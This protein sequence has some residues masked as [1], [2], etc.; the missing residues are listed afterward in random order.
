MKITFGTDGWR[1]RMDEYFNKENVKLIAKAIAKYVYSTGFKRGIFIGYDGRYNSNVFARLCAE[2]LSSFDIPSFLPPR[3]VPT[4]VAAFSVLKY[5]LDGAIMITASHNPPIYNGIK[6]IPHYGGP[7]TVEITNLIENLISK[8]GENGKIINELIFILNP[9]DDYI[10]HLLNLLSSSKLNIKVI[11]D[12]MHG[13]MAGIA[14]EVLSRIGMK[15]YVIRGNID[16]EFGGCTPDPIPKNLEELR[17]S[18]LS[19]EY[20]IGIAFDGDGDRLAAI[21]NRGLFLLAN[22]IL[23]II[24]IHMHDRRKIIGNAART[25]ATSHLIDFVV[26]ERNHEVFETPVGFKNIAPLLINRKIVIGG[27]E[28]GGIGFIN[29]I[30]E[31]DGLATALLLLEALDYENPQLTLENLYN[32]YGRFEFKRLDLHPHEFKFNIEG[33]NDIFGKKIINII[34]IDGLK[35]VFNDGSWLLIRKSGTENL[36]RI[37]S[38]ARTEYE[39]ES[40]IDFAKNF[41]LIT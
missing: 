1:S 8:G 40:L 20:D 4:P 11:I 14:E 12:P 34:K 28:S 13:S 36:I 24:Y 5:S 7:A 32:K 19:K 26:K 25:V 22:Q 39:V 15:V 37:Y 6:F 9:I 29:H 27:E 17:K 35:I 16:P 38:E 33:I 10:D 41:L 23:P 18:I 3:P 30:P 2:V 21:T 31:K